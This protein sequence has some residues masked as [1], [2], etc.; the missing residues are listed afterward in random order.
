MFLKLKKKFKFQKFIKFYLQR[1]NNKRQSILKKF[2]VKNEKTL[3]WNT[4]MN[5]S[6]HSP[7]FSFFVDRSKQNT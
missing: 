2:I 5:L 6:F 7:E 3:K 1:K 4:L